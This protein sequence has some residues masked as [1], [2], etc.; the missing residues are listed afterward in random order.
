MKILFVDT[1]YKGLYGAPKSMLALASGMHEKKHVVSVASTK[2][3][4]LLSS[5]RDLNLK[6]ISFETPDILLRSRRHHGV[7][8]LL[9]YF[10][11]LLFYW[12]KQ[13]KYLND[14][15]ADAICV[16]DIRAF[17]IF[18]PILFVKRKKVV[19]YVRINDRVSIIS[20]LASWLSKKIILISSDCYKCFN[21]FE[22]KK[23][24]DKFSIVNTGFKFPIKSKLNQAEFEH[25][26][27]DIIFISVGSICERKNQ[28]SILIAFEKLNERNKYLYLLGSPANEIDEEY[29]TKVRSFISDNNLCD[30]VKLVPHSPYVMDY[31]AVA[32]FFLFASHKEGLP[33]VVIESLYSGCYVVSSKVD[34]IYDII[35]SADLGAITLS[36]ASC[37][38]FQNEFNQCV[39]SVV[40][41]FSDIVNINN[42][43]LRMRHID[44]TFSFDCYI[45]NFTNV[46]NK[47]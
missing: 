26:E 37:D 28:I 13:V 35:N 19:W 4:T 47:L 2:E 21:D 20:C 22:L 1:Y 30:R 46:L 7:G 14:F 27:D 42:R 44:V 3:D 32:D 12:F 39:S 15:N 16:N 17:L 41:Q 23:F 34:G 45:D 24:K 10:I 33:R 8:T 40:S 9:N 5:A 43:E 18:F 36:S 38:S 6:T 29:D 31:L 25:S 11:T